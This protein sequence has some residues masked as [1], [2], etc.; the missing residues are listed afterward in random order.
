MSSKVLYAGLLASGQG[1][2]QRRACARSF[3]SPFCDEGV[4]QEVMT[5]MTR[6]KP[7]G[8]FICLSARSHNLLSNTPYTRTASWELRA[9]GSGGLGF[10]LKLRTIGAGGLGFPT[11]ARP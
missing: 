2:G 11:K 8:L 7:Q 3:A 4:A 5:V 6:R 9:I 1:Q 10:A